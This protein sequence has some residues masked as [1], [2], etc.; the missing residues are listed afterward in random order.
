MPDHIIAS[1]QF[2]I[3]IQYEQK[4]VT[5]ADV[6][7]YCKIGDGSWSQVTYSL[8]AWSRARATI[9]TTVV[10]QLASSYCVGIRDITSITTV[11]HMLIS[12]STAKHTGAKSKQPAKLGETSLSEDLHITYISEQHQEQPPAL[13]PVKSFSSDSDTS[14]QASVSPLAFQS[15][16][17]ATVATDITGNG[18]TQG[19]LSS[20]SDTSALILPIS[21]EP[22]RRRKAVHT[23][24]TGSVHSGDDNYDDD[25]AVRYDKSKDSTIKRKKSYLSTFIRSGTTQRIEEQPPVTN[26]LCSDT[27]PLLMSAFPYSLD[28]RKQHC[29]PIESPGGALHGA[30]S[31]LTRNKGR[32]VLVARRLSAGNLL[33]VSDLTHHGLA[34]NSSEMFV[35]GKICQLAK[36]ESPDTCKERVL[37]RLSSCFKRASHQEG[38]LP[39]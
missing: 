8:I 11:P 3:G 7:L 24:G 35:Y 30:V 12:Y 13:Y 37:S 22:L 34:H 31:N 16:D 5:D 32:R 38:V 29:R 14:T 4:A 39:K 27:A 25:D 28:T 6:R 18:S 20:I 33:I 19:P 21:G 1:V 15:Y 2:D 23:A 36:T 10:G 17:S 9:V 26:H